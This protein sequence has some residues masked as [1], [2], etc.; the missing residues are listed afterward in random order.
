MTRIQVCEA[1][2][3]EGLFREVPSESSLAA[4]ISKNTQVVSVGDAKIEL[5]NGSFVR[6]MLFDVD[7]DLIKSEEDIVLTMPY[8]SM[9]NK[10]KSESSRCPCCKQIRIMA[11]MEKCLICQRRGV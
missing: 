6:N 9:T 8:S 1:L 7:R 11:D 5:S 4:L 10:Q 2:H 3:D